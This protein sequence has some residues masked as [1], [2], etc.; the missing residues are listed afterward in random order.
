MWATL[1]AGDTVGWRDTWGLPMLVQINGNSDLNGI[2]E[3]P[4]QADFASCTVTL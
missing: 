4:H 3:S 1:R 2:T